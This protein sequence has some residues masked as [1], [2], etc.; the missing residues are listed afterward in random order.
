MMGA[1]G[2]NVPKV[3]RAE[4]ADA[5]DLV[6]LR[7]QMLADMGRSARDDA[8]PWRARAED[9][10]ADRLAR[11]QGF[12]SFVVDDPDDGVVACSAGICDLHAPG[13]GNPTGVRGH[14]FNMSTFPAHR[15][16]G[17]ARACLEELLKWFR[18]ETE[19]RVITLNA[20][21][22]GIALYRSVGF[23]EPRMAALQLILAEL[24]VAFFRPLAAGS[25]AAVNGRAS[26]EGQAGK[27]LALRSALLL[28][29]GDRQQSPEHQSGRD[30]E[31][32]DH[33]VDLD[34]PPPQLRAADLPPPRDAERRQH[35]GEL[36]IRP[37]QRVFD[38]GQNPFLMRFQAHPRSLQSGRLLITTSQAR[39]AC[40]NFHRATI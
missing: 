27:A 8:D 30:R 7:A 32:G 19:A 15:R 12:A 39:P 16:R 23:T 26:G 2:L 35:G 34:R 10:F 31:Q 17:Y 4:V 38:T 14:V 18:D 11:G 28:T 40:P 3:R 6:R 33:E 29:G 24:L 20:T 1:M 9:W 36:R 5:A 21:P 37:A 13:P 22:D 25:R